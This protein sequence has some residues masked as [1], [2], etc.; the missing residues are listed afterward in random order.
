MQIRVHCY[1]VQPLADCV[2]N[3]VL[4]TFMVLETENN[5]NVTRC[6]F[7]LKMASSADKAQLSPFKPR[8][9]FFFQHPDTAA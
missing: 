8:F 2:F 3:M 6:A 7:F 9:R 1:K 4:F 5:Q